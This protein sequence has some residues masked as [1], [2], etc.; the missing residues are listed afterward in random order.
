ME[1]LNDG[2]YRWCK[3][4]ILLTLIVLCMRLF[5]LQIL[6]GDE[7]RKLSEQNRVRVKKILA[8]RGMVYDRKGKVV[9]DT[10]AFNLYLIREDI[11]D[12]NQTVDGL[13]RL[14]DLDREDIIARLKEARDYPSSFPVKIE[15]D[16]NKDQVAKVEANQTMLAAVVKMR[17][18]WT[19]RWR[20]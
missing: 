6:K 9:A 5:D 4:I 17:A 12:F 7:M 1:P 13:A 15:S 18:S 11:R 14:L 19:R 8:P 10:P 16:L 20:K 3:R 2:K